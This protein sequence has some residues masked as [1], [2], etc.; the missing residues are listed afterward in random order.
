[1]SSLLPDVT[2]ATKVFPDHEAMSRAAA[3]HIAERADAVLSQ[4]DVFSLVLAGG[5][6]PKRLYELLAETPFRD[7]LPWKQVHIFW[8]DERFVPADDPASNYRMAWEALLRHVPIPS[9]NIHP[10]PTDIESP[11]LAAS[12]YEATLRTFT[13]D[14][15]GDCT[16]DCILLGLG[17][18]GHTASLFP[19]DA[20]H[21]APD[22]DAWV[23]A[24]TAPPRHTPRQ[25]VTLTLPA[26]NQSLD[27]LF[28]VS[29]A[30]KRDA[31][32]AVLD[33]SDASLPAAHVH[34]RRKLLWFLD[35]AAYDGE[36]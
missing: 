23:R 6:T 7:M 32:Q 28:L 17:R 30:G 20:P 18:D 22:T 15:S 8:G 9:G 21:A 19:E 24:V 3:A 16:F 31:A 10:I 33:R 35:E 25:R 26:I 36:S 2:P 5:G 12:K 1:M 14:Y 13:D 34:P 29:G 4:R 27:A 11:S